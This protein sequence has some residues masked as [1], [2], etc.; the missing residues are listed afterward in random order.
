MMKFNNINIVE[1]TFD[2]IICPGKID[3]RISI[4]DPTDDIECLL[5]PNEIVIHLPIIRILC[6]FP[7]E[8]YH[9][10]PIVAMN[11]I[12]FTRAELAKKISEIYWKLYRS[13]EFFTAPGYDINDLYLYHMFQDW[14]DQNIFRITI[15]N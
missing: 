3:D 4:S 9:L 8:N 10:I 1:I 13:D 6:H 15:D 12:N 7:F 5:R 11:G 14:K 2:Q